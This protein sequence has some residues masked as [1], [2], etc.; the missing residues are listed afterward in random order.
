MKILIV[1][2]LAAVCL[3]A[4]AQ[5]PPSAHVPLR[6]QNGA[7]ALLVTA[8]EQFIMT[9]N[10]G[11]VVLAESVT[12]GGSCDDGPQAHCRGRLHL[13]HAAGRVG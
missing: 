11:E 3:W 4:C 1:F 13:P 5:Q 6:L 7:G 12:A 2:C 9:T 8:G 10:M